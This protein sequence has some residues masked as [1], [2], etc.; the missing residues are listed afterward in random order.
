LKERAARRGAHR[1]RVD[2][3]DART[4]S[5]VEEGFRRWKPGEVDAWAMGMKARHSSVD[6]RDKRLVEEEK[7]RPVAR[8]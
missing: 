6:G 1:R 7:D 5:N 4:K 2:G 8:F 3:G